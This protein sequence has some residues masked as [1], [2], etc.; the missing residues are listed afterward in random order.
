MGED[1]G[2]AHGIPRGCVTIAAAGCSPLLRRR[3]K[4][5]KNFD[6]GGRIVNGCSA[7]SGNATGQGAIGRANRIPYHSQGWPHGEMSIAAL[8]IL[9]TGKA[10]GI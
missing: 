4:G 10:W 3:K 8:Q 5:K 2:G 9:Y 1:L 6:A 7:K